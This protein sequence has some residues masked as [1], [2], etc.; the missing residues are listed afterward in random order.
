MSSWHRIGDVMRLGSED[1][2]STPDFD[3]P[4][5]QVKNLLRSV[6]YEMRITQKAGMQ[7]WVARIGRPMELWELDVESGR[8]ERMELVELGGLFYPGNEQLD[9][10]QRELLWVIEQ[11]GLSEEEA[12][13]HT[14]CLAWHMPE[15]WR[16]DELVSSDQAYA[17]GHSEGRAT[18][19][20]L[21]ARAELRN[22]KIM[23]QLRQ[24]GRVK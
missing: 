22:T 5:V 7:C 14:D 20:P 12:V 23:A 4:R 18:C 17:Q 13:E 1:V 19:E 2:W 10:A 15:R 16:C 3:P 11:M 9:D 8:I 6:I 21:M 24:T